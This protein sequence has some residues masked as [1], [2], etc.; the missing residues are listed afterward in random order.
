MKPEAR[1]PPLVIALGFVSLFTDIAS[2]MMVP[3]LPVFLTVTLGASATFVGLVEGVA[4]GVAAIL[5]GLG[6]VWSD[7][8]QARRKWILGGYG[9]STL[10]RPL[11]ALAVAPWQV[12]ALRGTDR[13]GKGLRT[14][15]RDAL[16]TASIAPKSRGHAFGFH[17]AM[18]H[19]GALIGGLLAA[20][21]LAWGFS[22]R[23]VIGWSIIPGLL[24]VLV[25]VF[26]VRE[27]ASPVPAKPRPSFARKTLP[28][29]LRRYLPITGLFALANSSDAFL[30]L[31]A[32]QTGIPAVQIPL[33][34]AWIHVARIGANLVGGKLSDRIG[35]R[36]TVAAG[37]ICYSGV[38]LLVA[39][40]HTPWHMWAILGIY[41]IYDGLTEG[42]EKSLVSHLSHIQA[43]GT[44]FGAFHCLTGLA[45]VP[46]SLAAGLLWDHYGSTSAFLC[47]A[48]LALAAGLWLHFTRFE[49]KPG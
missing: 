17:R 40:A 44:A 1:L 11:I 47:G 14:A 49:A 15:P 23:E 29:D 9:I 21:L 39:L 24:A 46:A 41:G 19:S 20:G 5:K 3:V 22:A 34:W 37:W 6:G 4:E 33:L 25:I 16:I 7:A 36:R 26:F 10:A 31:K 43:T 13:V 28:P 35:A 27:P 45:A 2:E 8:G 30:L 48:I 18:D 32:S 38:Y 42:G 12:L